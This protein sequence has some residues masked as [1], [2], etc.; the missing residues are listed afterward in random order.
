MTKIL[1]PFTS[2]W[3]CITAVRRLQ[4]IKTDITLVVA[5]W[6]RIGGFNASTELL[7]QFL[8]CSSLTLV[9]YATWTET[10]ID[11][12]MIAMVRLVLTDYQDT[13]MTMINRIRGGQTITATEITADVTSVGYGDP[14]TILLI[15]VNLYRMLVW[16]R[17]TT[18]PA[19]DTAPEPKRPV[20]NII[21]KIFG[22]S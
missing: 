17:D 22:K 7:L 14:M 10:D 1:Q 16:L 9:E 11:D 8:K 12:K 6:N 19:P 5:E 21:K 13:L 2:L 18:L 4:R 15:L 20:L 3:S